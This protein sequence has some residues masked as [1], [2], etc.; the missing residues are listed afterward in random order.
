MRTREEEDFLYAEYISFDIEE[1]TIV[2]CGT[3]IMQCYGDK[4]RLINSNFHCSN[5]SSFWNEQKH[6]E[7]KKCIEIK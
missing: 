6:K 2:C 4:A 1:S 5:N 7:V 3:C